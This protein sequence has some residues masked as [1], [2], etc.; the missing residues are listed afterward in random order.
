MYT[1]TVNMY[2]Y[3]ILYLLVSVFLRIDMIIQAEPEIPY[4][5]LK[6]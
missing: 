4:V 2:I 1:N 3:N 6:W 5:L